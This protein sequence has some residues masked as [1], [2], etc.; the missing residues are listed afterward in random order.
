MT[1]SLAREV[2]IDTVSNWDIIK[3]NPAKTR[4]KV[5][6]SAAVQRLNRQQGPFP[7]TTSQLQG[8]TALPWKSALN[9]TEKTL[10]STLPVLTSDALSSSDRPFRFLRTRSTWMSH[11]WGYHRVSTW[12]TTHCAVVSLI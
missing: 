9:S 3:N 4:E 11:G 7:R 10:I 12:Q 6:Q 8:M 5:E 1:V 2:Q